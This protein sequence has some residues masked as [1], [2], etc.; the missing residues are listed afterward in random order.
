MKTDQTTTG[1]CSAEEQK[2][3]LRPLAVS[4]S[5]NIEIPKFPK[6][7]VIREGIARFCIICGSTMSRSGFLRLFGKRYCD[8]DECVN[9]K[10]LKNYR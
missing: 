4:G 10:P 6:S 7:R 1:V 5:S 8:S 3:Q 9:A 2:E